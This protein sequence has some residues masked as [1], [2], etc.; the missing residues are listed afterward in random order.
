MSRSTGQSPVALKSCRRPGVGNAAAGRRP[1]LL[2]FNPIR[3]HPRNLRSK[4]SRHLLPNTRQ[5]FLKIFSSPPLPALV[6]RLP[7]AASRFTA[8]QRLL[9]Y[10]SYKFGRG[11]AQMHT[12]TPMD[13]NLC[14]AERRTRSAGS[15][16]STLDRKR[17]GQIGQKTVQIYDP[18]KFRNSF[19]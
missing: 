14:N 7:T 4:T 5:E 19:P 12:I 15:C 17:S 18:E 9:K 2:V 3:V 10:L 1:A 16:P 11:I 8:D 13:T 6:S